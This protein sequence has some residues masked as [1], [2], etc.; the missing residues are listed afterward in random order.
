MTTSKQ[1]EKWRQALGS[2]FPLIGRVRRR[3][4]IRELTSRRSE[5]E[6]IRLLVEALGSADE[7]IAAEASSALRDLSAQEAIDTLCEEAIKAP[8]GPAARLCVATNRRHSDHEKN[9]L[10]LFVT[11]QL[12]VY[13][14][15]DLEFQ[16]LR[17]EYDRS[18][19]T[20]QRHVMEIVRGVDQRCTG[21][22]V[23]GVNR[24]G[25]PKP[26]TECTEAEI[27]LALDCWVRQ[28]Q[29]EILLQA[30]LELPLKYS[31]AVLEPLR[32]SGWQPESPDLKSVFKQMLSD[33]AGQAIPNPRKPGAE[34][35]L[36]ERWLEE[37]QQGE[38]AKLGEADLLNRLESDHPADGVAAVV[39][40]AAKVRPASAAAETVAKNPHWLVRLAGHATGLTQNLA[41]GLA[42]DTNWWVNKLATTPSVLGFW[43]GRATPAALKMLNKDLE[44]VW[45]GELD[46]A[47]KVLRTILAYRVES[48]G[49]FEP[50]VVQRDAMAD[51]PWF[52]RV[53]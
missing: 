9:C 12:D 22:S 28:G 3:M 11:R 29:W 4:A 25:E 41:Q 35:S 38:L 45:V 42:E 32:A 20:V 37:G 39:A 50:M 33:C 26:L 48:A 8:Q 40:L 36:F 17:L 53:R 2:S 47:R 13:F 6:V 15:K 14:Q 27:K 24:A 1:I 31:W 34:S 16:A 5:P 18:D 7:E 51:P 23:S 52:Y 10:Y 43:P 19:A 30:C 44:E 46:A 21:F 49:T